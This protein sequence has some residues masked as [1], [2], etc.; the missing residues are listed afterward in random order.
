MRGVAAHLEY[1][2]RLE[3]RGMNVGGPVKKMGRLV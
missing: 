1:R 2:Y 3:G